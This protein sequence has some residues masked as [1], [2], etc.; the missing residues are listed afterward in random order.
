MNDL[1]VM[2]SSYNDDVLVEL[3]NDI[4]DWKYITGIVKPESFLKTVINQN[5][6][7]DV[8]PRDIEVAAMDVAA[9]RFDKV[10][11]LLIQNRIYCKR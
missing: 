4:Y 2:I 7:Q 6:D 8:D 5:Q 3:L 1:N 11:S 10:V 9:S